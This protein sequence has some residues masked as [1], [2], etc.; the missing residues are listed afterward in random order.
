MPCELVDL[1]P[2]PTLGGGAWSQGW[3]P[4]TPQ[5][6]HLSRSVTL[7]ASAVSAVGMTVHTPGGLCG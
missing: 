1:I 6:C 3:G 5:L 2:E 4:S 7:S